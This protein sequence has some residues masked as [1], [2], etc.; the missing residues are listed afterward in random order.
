MDYRTRRI[1]KAVAMLLGKRGF[2]HQNVI[3]I[4]GRIAEEFRKRILRCTKHRTENVLF[5]YF[6]EA[7]KAI[8]SSELLINTKASHPIS[9][10]FHHIRTKPE[11]S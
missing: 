6:D 11:R 2:S 3:R 5:N 1:E 9:R 4:T 8:T 7:W 10:C